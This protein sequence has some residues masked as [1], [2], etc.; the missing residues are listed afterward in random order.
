MTNTLKNL[1]KKFAAAVLTT[2]LAVTMIPVGTGFA[3]AAAAA[4]LA[5]PDGIKTVE[6]DDDEITL[7]WNEVKGA[8]G[9]EIYRYSATY[10]KWIEVERTS[11]TYDE[12]DNLLSASVYTF[13]VRAF[14]QDASGKYIYSDFSAPFKTATSPKDVNNLRVSSKTKTSVTLKW[15]A[16]KRAD[17][18]QVYRYEKSTGEWK[19]LI[20]T[21]KT[22][23]TASGLSSGTSYKFKVRPY[24]EALGYKYY[25]DFEDITVKTVSSTSSSDSQYIGKAR[26]KQIA[27]DK[28]G[29]SA[30]KADFRYVKLDSDDG[31]KVYEVKFYAGDFEYEVEI[32]ARTGAVIDY[33]KDFRWDD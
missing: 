31:V 10:D 21:S 1:R 14:A 23:Y 16:V 18:Y 24:R 20:T 33:D 3:Y 17:K 22:S 25:G 8:S 11:N 26:A 13:K 15:N 32:N 6:R 27:L 2:A 4:S 7:K 5:A 12:V 19:R 30:S 28:A 29:V 9:Y